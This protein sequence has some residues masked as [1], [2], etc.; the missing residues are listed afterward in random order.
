MFMITDIALPNNNEE[1]FIKVAK[2]LGLERII[3]LYNLSDFDK[4][5][6]ANFDQTRQKS[7]IFDRDQ[8]SKE[9]LTFSKSL[10]SIKIGVICTNFKDLNKSLQ[11]AHFI[12]CKFEH[13][14]IR[15]LLRKGVHGIFEI[16][17]SQARLGKDHTH[18]PRSGLNQVLAKIMKKNNISY[19]QSFS[20]LLN[21]R[22]QSNTE[23]ANLLRRIRFNTTI[24]KKYGVEV[25]L[26]SF[27]RKPNDLRYFVLNEL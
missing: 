3:F 6:K 12:F 26:A 27:A 23:A 17:T 7:Q 25:N 16:E 20:S 13:E 2:E 24:C 5:A 11:K 1:E 14:D 15:N 21:S 22:Q 8:K 4:K 19:Y 9:F 10:I 18:Y